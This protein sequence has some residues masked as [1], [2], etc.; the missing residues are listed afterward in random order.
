MKKMLLL[1]L[2]LSAVFMTSC[3][4]ATELSDIGLVIAT[5]FDLDDDGNDRVTVLSV[6]P[7]G[8]AKEQGGGVI[9]LDRNGFGGVCF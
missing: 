3:W 6:Q 2:C 8:N 5:G 1:L 7:S 9:N 4:D